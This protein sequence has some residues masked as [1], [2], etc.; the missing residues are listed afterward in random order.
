[1]RR[2]GARDR[3]NRLLALRGYGTETATIATVQ[4]LG[5]A[6]GYLFLSLNQAVLGGTETLLFGTFLGVSRGQVLVLLLVALATLALIALTARPL[7]FATIDARRRA[8]ARPAGAR[9]RRRVSA[10][11]GPAVAATSQIT[12]VL[13][14]FALLVAPAAGAQLIT[15]RPLAGL[16]LS[17]AFALA[18]RVAGA[19]SRL[20]LDLS[21]RLLHDDVRV[22]VVSDRAADPGGAH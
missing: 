6:A 9:A 7:L 21:G 3:R 22:R 8:G 4:A 13:L 17:V 1:M 14:V 19:R 12:G 15:M 11:A 20:L 18:D 5:L 10:A 2:G 16:V